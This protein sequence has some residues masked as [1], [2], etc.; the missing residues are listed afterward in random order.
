MRSV[1]FSVAIP[2]YN[3]AK[4][5]S[6]VLA[7]L[8]AQTNL[9]AVVWEVI[10]IDNNSTDATA[11][12]VQA[13][14]ENWLPH[15]SLRYCFETRQG[16]AYGRQRAVKEAKGEFI[17]FLDDDNL[18]ALNWVAAA[19]EFGKAY[20][21]AGAYGGH[22]Q[23]N[24]EV[25]PPEAFEKVKSFLVI[26]NYANSAKLFEPEKL[27]LPPGA[28]L[29]VRKKAWLES[30]PDRLIRTQRGGN[31]YEISLHLHNRGWEI[32]YNPEMQIEHLIPAWR[33]E[34]QYVTKIAQLYGLC[35][36]EIRLIIAKPGQKPLLLIKSFLGGL[37]RL[38]TH[39]V[40][41]RDRAITDLGLACETA[42]FWGSVLSP[43]YYLQ[44]Q[45]I[46]MKPGNPKAGNK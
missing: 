37:R 12:V 5:L 10:V 31:D 3:G 19:C 43:F 15:T 26:R 24:Y 39:L 11:A 45:M 33:M 13:F 14:Q 18:P 28:G 17:G 42:F 8:K 2:T 22:I 29:V 32:W 36:C 30:V 6:L 1:D 27:R 7:R 44:Q 20:P 25:Q 21:K 9:E 4:T 38:V 16:L 35:T 34:R 23:G 41:H 46:R 40:K